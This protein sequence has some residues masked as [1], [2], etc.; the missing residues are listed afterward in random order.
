MVVPGRTNARIH[1]QPPTPCTTCAVKLSLVALS[2]LLLADADIVDIILNALAL[3]FVQDV[4]N[5]LSKP[6]QQA[7]TVQAEM[8]A[9]LK[10]MM[11]DKTSGKENVATSPFNSSP[12]VHDFLQQQ[13]DS[14]SVAI[15]GLDI[16]LEYPFTCGKEERVGFE[17]SNKRI[18]HSTRHR[19]S[20]LMKTIDLLLFPIILYFVVALPICL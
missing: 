19:V 3:Q 20:Q 8:K 17:R 14:S 1:T 6:V 13:I 11:T 2:S 9:W 16:F 18:K 10:D 12:F 7:A 5:M 15:L 4:D